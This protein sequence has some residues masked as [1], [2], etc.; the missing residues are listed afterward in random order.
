[1]DEAD[2]LEERREIRRQLRELRNKKF[3]EE[4]KKVTAGDYR[5]SSNSITNGTD[6]ESSKVGKSSGIKKQESGE[7]DSYGLASIDNEDELQ[8]LVSFHVK[9]FA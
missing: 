6:N 9:Y 7:E 3:E 4:V 1:M 5:P 8:A 2:S